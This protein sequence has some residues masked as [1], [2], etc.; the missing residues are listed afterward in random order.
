MASFT[1]LQSLFHTDR[2][3]PSFRRP[4]VR[5]CCCQL[6]SL[7]SRSVRYQP[8]RLV[9]TVTMVPVSLGTAAI[10]RVQCAIFAFPMAS[11]CGCALQEGGAT[12]LSRLSLYLPNHA[13]F[14]HCLRDGGPGVACEHLARARSA[15][16]PLAPI[17]R[18]LTSTQRTAGSPDQT[19]SW[20][21]TLVVRVSTLT[22]TLIILGSWAFYQLLTLY[23]I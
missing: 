22:L 18:S 4:A 12:V 23:G 2:P 20:D 15:T 11:W 1:A 8:T 17:H 3:T 14:Q 9:Q 10:V 6:A 16:V 7:A 21:T 13:M 19:N 5:Q